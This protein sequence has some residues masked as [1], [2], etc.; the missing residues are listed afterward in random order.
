MRSMFL[1]TST[2]RA[3]DDRAENVVTDGNCAAN[4]WSGGLKNELI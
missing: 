3:E 2:I 4:L 1:V